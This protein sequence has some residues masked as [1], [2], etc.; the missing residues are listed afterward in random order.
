MLVVSDDNPE[1]L[2]SVLQS[3]R[4]LCND[5]NRIHAV[6]C[7]STHTTRR[8]YE[9]VTKEFH[10]DVSFVG[11]AQS[12]QIQPTLVEVLQQVTTAYVVCA[13]DGCCINEQISFG[14]CIADLERTRA[15]GFYLSL[16]A[17]VQ[18]KRGLKRAQKIPPLVVLTDTVRAWHLKDGEHD[19]RNPFSCAL[20]V[21]RTAHFKEHVAACACDDFDTLQTMLATEV[22]DL[23]A[24]GLCYVHAP[25]TIG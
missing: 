12:A 3:V 21:Y 15:H 22:V 1:R 20:S 16:G 10:D 23:R 14:T 25:V 2:K 4:S 13:H 6:Y 5:V 18:T 9:Q 8:A 24:M 11:C 17:D 19:W 7:A